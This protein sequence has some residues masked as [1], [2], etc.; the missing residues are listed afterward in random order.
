MDKLDKIL[1]RL[2]KH[3][4][5]TQDQRLVLDMALRIANAHL[6]DIKIHFGTFG[7]EIWREETKDV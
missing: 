4:H 3:N 7:L 6:D 2:A 1:N 5:I